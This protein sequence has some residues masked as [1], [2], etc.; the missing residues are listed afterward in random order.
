[1]PV[2]ENLGDM[3]KV[4]KLQRE[5]KARKEAELGEH[6][7][8]QLRAAQGQGSKVSSSATTPGGAAS[9]LKASRSGG[10]FYRRHTIS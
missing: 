8:N 1:M 4:T 9:S 5:R 2:V 7:L 10:H 6:E 3:W